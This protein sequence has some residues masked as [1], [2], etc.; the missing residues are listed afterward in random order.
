MANSLVVKQLIYGLAEN[1]V[2]L[3]DSRGAIPARYIKAK[4]EEYKEKI[5]MVKLQFLKNQR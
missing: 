5:V 4:V 3:A 2:G 1:G